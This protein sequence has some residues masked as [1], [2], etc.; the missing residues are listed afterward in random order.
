MMLSGQYTIVMSEYAE[1]YV[2]TMEL[3]ECQGINAHAHTVCVPGPLF[4]R[5]LGM[6]LPVTCTL[7]LF[8]VRMSR[9]SWCSS[10]QKV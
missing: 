6:R 5:G 7:P 4:G 3:L 2:H 9:V 8:C 1:V 10:G